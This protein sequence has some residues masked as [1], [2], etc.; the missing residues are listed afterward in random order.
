ML[1][2]PLSGEAVHPAGRRAV[3]CTG[4]FNWSTVT[5]LALVVYVYAVEVQRGDWSSILAGL[6]F[7]LTDWF[8]EIVNALVLHVNGDDAAL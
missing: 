5:L 2:R 1:P 7:L 4:H 8:N 6:A 3:A